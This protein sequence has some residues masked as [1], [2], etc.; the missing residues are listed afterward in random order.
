MK[1]VE[2]TFEG[3]TSLARSL[4]TG[5]VL[6]VSEHVSLHHDY[7]IWFFKSHSKGLPMTRL[8]CHWVVM[9]LQPKTSIVHHWSERPLGS[10]LQCAWSENCRD[11]IPCIGSQ[12]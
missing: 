1:S 8:G 2:R 6:Q 5:Q 7:G 9:S 11:D 3:L 10:D 4:A 12:G